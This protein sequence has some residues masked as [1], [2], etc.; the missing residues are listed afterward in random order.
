MEA[1]HEI[2][3]NT[4]CTLVNANT[5]RPMYKTTSAI[6][7]VQSE[8]V[9]QNLI[10]PVGRSVRKHEY[11]HNYTSGQATKHQASY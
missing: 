2:Q 10:W 4:K 7:Y 3:T 6:K 1:R 8:E 9:T 11:K 5:I